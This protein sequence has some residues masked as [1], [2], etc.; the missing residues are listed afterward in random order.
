MTQPLTRR[1]TTEIQRWLIV[2]LFA[3]VAAWMEA[4]TVVYWRTLL[5][6][7][8]P[9][10][11]YPL[12]NAAG[13]C[14]REVLREAAALLMYLTIGLLAGRSWR[15]RLGYALIVLGALEIFYYVCLAILTGWPRSILDW[16]LLFLIPLP[17]WGPVIAPTLIAAMLVAGGTLVTQFD[18][19][20]RP[21]W[22]NHGA[23]VLS[24]LG[25]VLA[26]YVFMHDALRAFP[27][28]IPGTRDVLPTKFPWALFVPALC[29]MSASIV[30]VGRQ[31]WSRQKTR[32][33]EG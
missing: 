18:E 26:L 25:A 24:G 22:P 27:R 21:V 30:D 9:Y 2:V 6:R 16:D 17:W 14:D 10:Q 32:A 13:L 15:S 20:E 4:T 5:G 33:R 3:G 11:P 19:I 31:V 28:G 23:L 12:P 1:D 7:L 8:D 29:L